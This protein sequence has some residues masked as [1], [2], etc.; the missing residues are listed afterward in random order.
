[1]SALKDL[2][3]YRVFEAIYTE[4]SITRA[5]IVLNR[6]QPALS[7]SL[8]RLREHFGDELFVRHGNRLLPTPVARKIIGPVR[9]ALAVLGTVS[10]ASAQFD[11]ACD[12]AEFR[13]SMRDLL[14]STMLPPMVGR[15]RSRAPGVMLST[16]RVRRADI[17][18]RLAAG[19]LDLAVDVRFRPGAAIRDEPVRKDAFV[20]AARCGALARLD[21][22]AYLA[23]GH[24]LVSSREEGPAVEDYGLHRLGYRRRIAMRCQTYYA[25]CLAAMRSDLLVT[26]PATPA[27]QVAERLPELELHPLPIEIPP[28]STHL[29]WHQRVDADPANRWLREQIVEALAGEV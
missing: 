5:G 10:R 25:A 15:L 23:A 18:S 4:R 1:M 24:V 14:E 2:N 19:T 16:A 17:P 7:Y 8:A 29:Y 13:I 28:V 11:P 12:H 26:L 22:R 9:E 3:L 6:S 20:V 27:H 21:E